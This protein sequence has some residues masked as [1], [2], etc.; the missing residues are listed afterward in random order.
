MNA[1]AY[2]NPATTIRNAIQRRSPIQSRAGERTAWTAA[3]MGAHDAPVR[4]LPHIKRLDDCFGYF[5]VR[6]SVSVYPATSPAQRNVE[7][8][9]MGRSRVRA[10]ASPRNS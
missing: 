10:S 6:V 8:D 1:H 4:V 5:L 3:A 2:V 7:R 9:L